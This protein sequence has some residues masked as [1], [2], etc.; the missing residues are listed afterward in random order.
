MMEASRFD[1]AA[2]VLAH[3]ASRRGTFRA[4]SALIGAGT[5]SRVL[6]PQ[7]VL[8]IRQSAAVCPDGANKS[9]FGPDPGFAQT[10][11]PSVSGKLSEARILVFHSPEVATDYVIKIVPVDSSGN[12]SARRTLA[13]K[14]IPF[15]SVDL[16]DQMLIATFKKR[17]AAKVQ[18]EKTYAVFLQGDPSA[19]RLTPRSAN[20]CQGNLFTY[21]QD[22]RQFSASADHDAIFEVFVGYD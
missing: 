21:N 18:A 11:T 12:P 10:F 6:R 8:A 5:L 4:L 7:P 14:L 17:K 13:K 20:P 1:T 3:T 15:T 22:S 16:G 2:R 9:N 19:L